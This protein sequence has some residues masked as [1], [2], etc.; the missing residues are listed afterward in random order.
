VSAKGLKAGRAGKAHHARSNG[1][2]PP[3]SMP[4]PL[5]P[6]RGLFI[7]LC[8]IFAAWVGGLVAMYFKTVYPHRHGATTRQ[9]TLR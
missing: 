6:R 7:A 8:L 5:K 3:P 9:E 2:Q 1:G 4:Q